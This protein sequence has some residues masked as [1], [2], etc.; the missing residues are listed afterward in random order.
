M[1]LA[2]FEFLVADRRVGGDRK[3]QVIDG[4]FAGPVIGMGLVADHRVLLIG[5]ELERPGTDRL[6]VDGS[7]DSGSHEFIRILLRVNRRE[8]HA[9][10]GDHRRLGA[11]EYEFYRVIVYLDDLLDQRRHRHAVI[12]LIGGSGGDAVK[13][14]LLVMLPHEGKD[15]VVGVE[16][17]RRRELLGGME[18]NSLSQIE[19]VLQTVV[20]NIPLL[21]QGRDDLGGAALEFN[22]AVEDCAG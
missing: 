18:F 5:D 13:R 20:G 10:V 8:I 2:G 9:Q 3:Y 19:G 6:L 21:G 7:R 14:M 11:V 17:A 1:A 12:I 4:R 22:Q 16:I 15:H